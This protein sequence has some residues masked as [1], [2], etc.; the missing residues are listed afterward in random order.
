M[1]LSIL[2]KN[3]SLRLHRPSAVLLGTRTRIFR[4]GPG[5]EATLGLYQVVVH[6]AQH[7]KLPG[8]V[9]V[10]REVEMEARFQPVP[11][12]GVSERQELHGFVG[13]IW[14]NMFFPWSKQGFLFPPIQ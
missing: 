9:V 8:A 6:H 11:V 2:S 10:L 7:A 1:H 4:A 13:K 5:A 3:K 14:K 12:P